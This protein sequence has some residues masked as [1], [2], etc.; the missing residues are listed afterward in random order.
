MLRSRRSS[1][2]PKLAPIATALLAGAIG[3]ACVTGTPPDL[4]QAPA[5]RP[6]IH[7]EAAIPEDALLTA[8][9]AEF[10][11][12]VEVD[13]P[14]PGATWVVLIDTQPSGEQGPIPTGSDPY[15]VMFTLPVPLA[16]TQ[17]HTIEF[18][19]TGPENLGADTMTWYYVPEGS[20]AGCDTFDAG[21][22]SGVG[23]LPLNPADAATP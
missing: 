22:D 10:V 15:L 9:P 23:P 12:P 4:P 19:V 2:P 1:G 20:L 6:I 11:V 16:P 7:R 3:V 13:T 5:H 8:L 14:S 17:C 21:A 18:L